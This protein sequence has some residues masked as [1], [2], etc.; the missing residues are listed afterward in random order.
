MDHQDGERSGDH[1]Q[2]RK[3]E[4]TEGAERSRNNNCLQLFKM[5][6]WKKAWF[7]LTLEGRPSTSTY[8]LQEDRSD[9][10]KRVKLLFQLPHN[11]P[12]C[13]RKQWI[14]NWKLS[15]VESPLV[16]DVLKGISS[17]EIVLNIFNVFFYFRHSMV[18]WKL[19][20]GKKRRG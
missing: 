13:F 18:S 8:R 12:D 4:G 7:D 15:E 14:Y 10:M 19:G 16:R 11:S 5:L 1:I 6:W 20:P 2:W 17:M 3:M 9:S